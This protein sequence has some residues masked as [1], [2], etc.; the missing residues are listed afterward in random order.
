MYDYLCV[1]KLTSHVYNRII[2]PSHSVI[3]LSFVDQRNL[4]S[5]GSVPPNWSAPEIA[6]KVQEKVDSKNVITAHMRMMGKSM[7]SI[8][9]CLLTAGGGTPR[10]LSQVLSWGRYPKVSDPR[11][12]PGE[13]RVSQSG[14]YWGGGA[15]VTSVRPLGRGLLQSGLWPGVSLDSTQGIFMKTGIVPARIGIPPR[16]PTHTHRELAGMCVA[17]GMSFAVT[18]DDFFIFCYAGAAV[19]MFE[20]YFF[21]DRSH[22]GK[23]L[24]NQVITCLENDT[25][26]V[27]WIGPDQRHS[28]RWA[29]KFSNIWGKY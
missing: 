25:V 13:E 19:N 26:P 11:S 10:S 8:G 1:R 21:S 7:F 15:G 5:T 14:M 2:Y 3:F 22:S 16:P 6:W 24:T 18:L 4:K 20:R 17:G 27:Q 29:E 23:Q 28:H 12:F 9:V